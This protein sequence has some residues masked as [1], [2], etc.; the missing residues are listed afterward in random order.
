M[1]YLC[2]EQ[3]SKICIINISWTAKKN[4]HNIYLKQQAAKQLGYN[5]EIWIYNENKQLVN[6]VFLTFINGDTDKFIT[7]GFYFS[8]DTFLCDNVSITA[9][10]PTYKLIIFNDKIR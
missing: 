9:N 5:Y 10:D 3:L 1:K 8:I 7:D 4:K 6:L 2:F